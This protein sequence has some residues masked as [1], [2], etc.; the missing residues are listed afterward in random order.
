MN[1][2]SEK[3]WEY[4]IVEPEEIIAKIRP[5]M[6]LFIGSAGAEPRTMVRQLLRAGRDRLEDVELVQ[7]LSFGAAVSPEALAAEH[8]RLKTFFSG[9]IAEAAVRDGHVD[10]VPSRLIS[11]PR[12]I[13]SGLVAI[14][15][16]IVQISPPNEEGLCSLGVSVD[17]AREAME[18]ATVTVGEI[19]PDAPFTFGD[20][21][22][23]A[24]DFDFLVVSAEKPLYFHRWPTC[25]AHK[26]I[27]ARLAQIIEDGS[28]VAFF[29]GPL[30][31]ELG[32]ELAKKRHLGIHSPFF[33]D[34]LMDLMNSGAVTNRRKGTYRG[35]SLTSYAIGTSAL[36]KWLDRNPLVEFQRIDKVFDPFVIGRNPKF[37]TVVPAHTVDLYGRISLERGRQDVASCPTEVMDLSYGAELSPGGR[38]IFALPSRNEK[39]KT[40][41]R[42]SIEDLPN[43]YGIYESVRIVATEYGLAYLEGHTVRGRAQALIEIAHPDD[44]EWL[45]EMARQANILYKDQIFL[46]GSGRLYPKEIRAE[47]VLKNERVCRFRPI[48]PSDE[49][50]MR[51]LFYRFSNEAVYSRYFVRVRSMPHE[52]MQGYVNVDW[53]HVMSI[54]GVVGDE[55]STLLVAEARFIRIPGTALAEVEFVVDEAFQR[56]GI[57]TFL[58]NML[59]RLARERGVKE[60]RASVLFSNASMMKVFRKGGLPVKAHLENGVYDLS[61]RL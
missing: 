52:K 45:V 28:C 31:E 10:F 60:F 30:F 4:K 35:K 39:G 44:R 48:K 55:S 32:K 3:D 13:E 15:V 59:I 22:V 17:V 29:I 56:M 53:K 9:W 37:V 57:A 51:R 14:D 50:G 8:L 41:I 21:F 16:A 2:F 46:A 42:L 25:D 19:Q 40:N 38:T 58:Y 7:L 18:K 12:L 47:F 54:V 36:L 20:T 61:I 43:P 26:E 5:G 24:A 23:H 6:S 49:E 1:R 33:T 11:I 27:A 34:A